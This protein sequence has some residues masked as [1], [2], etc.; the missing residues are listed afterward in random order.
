MKEILK[1]RSLKKIVRRKP[2][3]RD[4]NLT[5]SEGEI[6]GLIG[7]NG[8]GKTTLLKIISGSITATAGSVQLAEPESGIGVLPE[9][10]ALL[11]SL[12]GF[13][14]LQLLASIRRKAR[15][16]EIRE[17]MKTV[18]LDP[19][20]RKAVGNYSLGMKQRLMLAQAIM[21]KPKLLLLDEPT[22][23]L[24]P[25]GI[26]DLRQLLFRLASQGVGIIIASHL[27]HEIEL[28]CHRVAIISNGSIV[29]EVNLQSSEQHLIE[30][31]VNSRSDWDKLVRW[32]GKDNLRP[33]PSKDFPRGILNSE[34]PVS[35]VLAEL[36]PAGIA[37][38]SI[39]RAAINLEA[40]FLECSQ[41]K[42]GVYR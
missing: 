34:L 35:R 9:T 41:L 11:P 37:I 27:L 15:E 12:S 17:A 42:D 20:N 38:E 36:L 1:I 2:I 21:E 4:I 18:G 25:L 30:I 26:I 16:Q 40:I 22:N 6:L 29:R 33:L 19:A 39:Q 24:D 3:L 31:S 13:Q 8:A 28:M 10:P 23:G 14:N 7:P 32:A 5:L